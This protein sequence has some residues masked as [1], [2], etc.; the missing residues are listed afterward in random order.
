LTDGGFFRPLLP[1]EVQAV[2]GQFTTNPGWVWAQHLAERYGTDASANGNGQAGDNYAVGGARVAADVVGQLGP[3]PSVVS[4][5]QSFVGAGGVDPEALYTVWGG[6]NDVFAVAAGAPPEK[7]IGT[8][9]A[10]QIGAIGAL[11][12]A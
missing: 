8:A 4:Q 5:V 11:Q 9:V 12:G 6:A 7:T 1:P 3:T 10:A 2:T